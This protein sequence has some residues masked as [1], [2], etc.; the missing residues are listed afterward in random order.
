MV[1]FSFRLVLSHLLT[2]R[3]SEKHCS[4]N[5]KSTTSVEFVVFQRET[6]SG[7]DRYRVTGG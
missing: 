1:Y 7:R 2:W 5:H 6:G 3:V 4:R